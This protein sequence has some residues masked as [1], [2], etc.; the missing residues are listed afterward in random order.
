MPTEIDELK[1]LAKELLLSQKEVKEMF[2]ETDRRFKETDEQF[3]ETDRRFKKTDEQFKETDRRIKK[4]FQKFESQWGKLVES[5]VEGDIIRIL[6]EKG[7][8]VHDTSQRRKGEHDGRHFEFDIIAHNGKEIVIIE[9]KTTLRVNDVKH[10]TEKL[11]HAK[12]WMEEYKDFSIFG[13]V[14]FL[15]DESGAARF[16]EKEKLFVIKATGN[17]AAIVNEKDFVPRKF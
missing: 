2:K 13:A 9:V 5:L 4:A 15:K 8:D 3:K 16:A 1:D 14:A 7:I 11:E 17:S 10:F 12:V 6:R